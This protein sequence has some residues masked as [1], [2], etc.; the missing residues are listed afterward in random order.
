MFIQ[1]E[2]L[3]LAIDYSGYYAIHGWGLDSETGA[4]PQGFWLRP[5]TGTPATINSLSLV[6]RPDVN[7]A[8][9]LAGDARVGFSVNLLDAFNSRPSDYEL[10]YREAPLFRL[11]EHLNELAPSNYEMATPKN[12]SGRKQ[13]LIVYRKGGRLHR[14]ISS[15]LKW[16]SNFFNKDYCKGVSFYFSDVTDVEKIPEDVYEG[17]GNAKLIIER[18]SYRFAYQFN[19]KKFS[20]DVIIYDESDASGAPSNG[21]FRSIM[22]RAKIDHRISGP[23]K[24]FELSS[25]LYGS[26]SLFFPTNS[27]YLTVQSG[28][29]FKWAIEHVRSIQED[30]SFDVAV[31]SEREIFRSSDIVDS[32]AFVLLSLDASRFCLDIFDAS[33]T[34]F[35]NES[36]RRGLRVRFFNRGQLDVYSHC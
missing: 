16:Q 28:T 12:E 6:P 36:F 20:G 25:A 10:F 1:H 21:L 2:T 19:L 30:S 18:S 32:D 35:I 3:S 5:N 33:P 11:T 8:Y 14:D 31:Y 4:F 27:R 26:E 9:N 29:P 7:N 34:L 17:K 22:A 13:V 23:R 24:L 15:L